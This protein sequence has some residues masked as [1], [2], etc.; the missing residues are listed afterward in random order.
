MCLSR[1]RRHHMGSRIVYIYLGGRRL[2]HL[3]IRR[4][5]MGEPPRHG[6]VMT[7]ANAPMG[8]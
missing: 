5:S 2:K 4:M 7:K 8:G 1:L 3:P 6:A